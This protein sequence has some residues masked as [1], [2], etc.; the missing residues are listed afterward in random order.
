MFR[1]P[2]SPAELQAIRQ[3]TAEELQA[4][5]TAQTTDAEIAT[6]A[7]RLAYDTGSSTTIAEYMLRLERRIA[8]LES[9]PNTRPALRQEKA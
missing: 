5:I 4:V 8:A 1:Q 3:Q 2:I 7:R 9:A 6:R